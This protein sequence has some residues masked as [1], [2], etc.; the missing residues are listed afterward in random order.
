M[1]QLVG[2][3]ESDT[4]QA[5]RGHCIRVALIRSWHVFTESLGTIRF[6]RPIFR[7]YG[8]KMCCVHRQ[9]QAENAVDISDNARI[10]QWNVFPG[11]ALALL[12]ASGNLVHTNVRL[13][14]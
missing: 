11:D 7:S 3:N 8:L 4:K 1:E 12:L 13:E 10:V 14:K 9:K 2:G 5:Q 6:D